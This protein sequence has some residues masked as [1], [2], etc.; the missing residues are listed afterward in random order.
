MK[1][2]DLF[3]EGFAEEVQLVPRSTLALVDRDEMEGPE[4]EALEMGSCIPITLRYSRWL[5]GDETRGQVTTWRVRLYGVGLIAVIVMPERRV[6]RYKEQWWQKVLT[7]EY[8]I[9]RLVLR[10]PAVSK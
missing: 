10:V 6:V 1:T 7:D 9:A 4:A 3:V 8:L 5:G 2:S